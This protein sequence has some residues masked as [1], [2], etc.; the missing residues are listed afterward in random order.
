M[1]SSL[2]GRRVQM[3]TFD[4]FFFLENFFKDFQDFKKILK[5]ILK[6]ITVNLQF[7]PKTK[8]INCPVE[9]AWSCTKGDERSFDLPG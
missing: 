7:I 5:K 2:L 1:T 9:N 8:Q 4:S 6:K 3:H